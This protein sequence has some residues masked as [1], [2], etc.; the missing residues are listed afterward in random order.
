MTSL[1]LEILAFF[2]LT[3]VSAR[4]V[5]EWYSPTLTL[6][7]ELLHRVP[8]AS[9]SPITVILSDQ[10]R[11]SH[12]ATRTLINKK[13]K[14]TPICYTPHLKLR[15]YKHPP[16]Q[17]SPDPKEDRRPDTRQYRNPI[18]PQP[19]QNPLLEIPNRY[20]LLPLRLFDLLRRRPQQL[21]HRSQLISAVKHLCQ[22]RL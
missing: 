9:I 19:N 10:R 1:L 21:R 6:I 15:L 4:S 16:P 3:E 14:I 8:S 2:V 22:G 13:I 17:P 12:H 18:N 20:R 11:V 7:G 5:F